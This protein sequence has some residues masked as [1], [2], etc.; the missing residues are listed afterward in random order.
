MAGAKGGNLFQENTSGRDMYGELAQSQRLSSL[1][2]F[3]QQGNRNFYIY[4]AFLI[5]ILFISSDNI[6]LHK[7][8]SN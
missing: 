5:I 6:L 1:L 8:D 7:E 2:A 4:H 3:K